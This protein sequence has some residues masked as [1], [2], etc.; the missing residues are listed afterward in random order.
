MIPQ[1][2]RLL[3]KHELPGNIVEKWQS[4]VD[5]LAELESVKVS[6]ILKI[7]E[8][9]DVEI[10]FTNQNK[11]NPFKAGE[12]THINE[13]L[14]FEPVIKHHSKLIIS[15]A[16]LDNRWQTNIKDNK[17]MI[18]CI[19]LP[20]KIKNDVSYGELCI[21]DSKAHHYS[22]KNI[23]LLNYF[24]E[25]IQY[26]LEDIFYKKDSDQVFNQLLK[27][28]NDWNTTKIIHICSFCKKIEDK[29]NNWVA[30]EEYFAKYLDLWFSHGICPNCLEKHYGNLLN[31]QNEEKNED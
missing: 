21:L 12:K 31:K 13:N 20:I 29:N 1:S 15:N 11:E 26:Q 9:D 7:I 4:I 14:Y 23:R 17:G 24:K 8:G 30:F 28:K 16:L 2:R 19:C 27:G 6:L 18:S 22:P 10:L 3:K 5:L 25:L